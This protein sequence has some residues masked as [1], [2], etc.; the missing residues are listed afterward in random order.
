MLTAEDLIDTP[1]LGR[2]LVAAID[3]RGD[4]AETRDLPVACS[5]PE[6]RLLWRPR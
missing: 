6:P 2:R 3:W 1:L 4:Q 5:A